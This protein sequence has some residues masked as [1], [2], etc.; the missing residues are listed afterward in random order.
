MKKFKCKMHCSYI[1]DYM[2]CELPFTLIKNNKLPF[3]KDT[4]DIAIMD[5]VIHHMA[6]EIQSVMLKEA[7]RIVKKLLI[8]E[9]DRTTVALILDTIFSKI[10]H[11]NMQIP[12]LIGKGMIGKSCL[13]I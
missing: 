12:I 7:S 6:P 10:Q 2:E 3:K 8:V 13:I 5:D 1:I 9:T 4:F 11:F